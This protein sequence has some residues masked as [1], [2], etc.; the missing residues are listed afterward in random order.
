MIKFFRRIRQK[1]LNEGSLNRYL[2]YALGEILLVVIGILIAVQLN[3]LN[4]NNSIRK[5]LQS[6]YQNLYLD[7]KTDTITLNELDSAL[8]ENVKSI[9]SFK[10]LLLRK[11]KISDILELRKIP[12]LWNP[13]LN[14]SDG[15]YQTLLGT[16]LLYNSRND[17]FILQINEYY[18]HMESTKSMMDGMGEANKFV[19]DQEILIPFRYIINADNTFFSPDVNSL[20]W[21]NDPRNQIYQ[22]VHNYL[23][24]S[25]RQVKSKQR[26][27]NKAISTNESVQQVVVLLLNNKL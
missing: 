7:L 14:Y 20:L 27:L 6:S 19:R 3:N 11:N 2:I 18:K 26:E 9:E 15:T 25:L 5:E 4:Q 16:G 12:R 17:E 22:A 24:F 21:M 13:G 1:L 8:T 10:H 23:N